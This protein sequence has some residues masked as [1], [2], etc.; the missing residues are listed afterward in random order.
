MSLRQSHI[1]NNT[2]KLPEPFQSS[3]AHRFFKK[4]G[5]K[6]S[7][8][9]VKRE[10]KVLVVNLYLILV[11]R[12]KQSGYLRTTLGVLLRPFYFAKSEES[13]KL[14]GLEKEIVQYDPTLFE[15]INFDLFSIKENQMLD[16]STWKFHEHVT[17]L[18]P[19]DTLKEKDRFAMEL[20]YAS[21]QIAGNTYTYRQAL[22][23][24]EKGIEAIN[25]PSHERQMIIN[26]KIAFDFIF[27][28]KKSFLSLNA[29]LLDQLHKILVH[30]MGTNESIRDFPLEM[31]GT[32][33]RPPKNKYEIN[34]ELN[35][36]CVSVN[37]LDSPYSKALL[38]HAGILYISPYEHGSGRIARYAADAILL[39]YSYAPLSWQ[40]FN[41]EYYKKACIAFYEEK[42]IFTLKKIFMDEYVFAAQNCLVR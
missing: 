26:K 24:F 1:M 27:K 30:K 16:N 29:M 37:K 8:I 31:N 33:Y 28:E 6:V 39:A 34:D 20:C 42:N 15:K 21:S 23:L 41:N 19:R 13:A 4:I 36:L 40:S 12:G 10:I 17:R 3:D 11:G 14:K 2:G 22:R 25:H 9:T 32:K 35:D 18:F 7:L 38:A 5:D